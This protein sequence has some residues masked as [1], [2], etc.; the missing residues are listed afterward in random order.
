MPYSR[1]R[2]R[3][4]DTFSGTASCQ[5]TCP[6]SNTAP[7]GSFGGSKYNGKRESISDIVWSSKKSRRNAIGP[8]TQTKYEGSHSGIEHFE[9]SL[10]QPC[11]SPF[12]GLPARRR[13]SFSSPFYGSLAFP[14]IGNPTGWSS[15]GTWCDKQLRGL[16]EAVPAQ[17]SLPNFLLE[18]GDIRQL[19]PQLRE[20]ATRLVIPRKGLSLKNIA[21]GKA[22]G[23][24]KRELKSVANAQLVTQFALLPLVQ[25]IMSIIYAQERV[26]KKL[27]WLRKNNQQ[28]V[29]VRR[30]RSGYVNVPTSTYGAGCP[31]LSA[32]VKV[33]RE[34][35]TAKVTEVVGAQAH[36]RYDGL[37]APLA[38]L[39]ALRSYFGFNKPF[40]V[41]WEAI[42]FSWLIDYFAHLDELIDRLPQVP[43]FTGS[44]SL[45]NPWFSKKVTYSYSFKFTTTLSDCDL[46][47][48]N[49]ANGDFTSYF[50]TGTVP[51]GY[52]PMLS[53]SLK[54]NQILNTLALLT[55]R[56]L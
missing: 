41:I 16:L 56:G 7:Q 18:L 17:T 44:P 51:S 34:A 2:Q 50:R 38:E 9:W 33:K 32:Q 4:F 54:G 36:L 10:N 12:T 31:G 14:S 35:I 42:P 47:G 48:K 43:S 1:T 24:L 5:D 53:G 46:D 20:L 13:Y 23:Q 22:S 39:K 52:S 25:D 49:C 15:S 55:Q 21:S 28:R 45:T 30:Y 6:N 27:N 3:G 8:C 40:S 26:M 19:V 37:D 11:P 29:T